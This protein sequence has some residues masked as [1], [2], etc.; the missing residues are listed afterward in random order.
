MASRME[1]CWLSDC[2]PYSANDSP[3]TIG[4]SDSFSISIVYRPACFT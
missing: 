2:S 1:P 4:L 3:S